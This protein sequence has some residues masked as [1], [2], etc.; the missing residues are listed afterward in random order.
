MNK[1]KPA[2]E[3][4]RKGEYFA[5]NVNVDTEKPFL[6]ILSRHNIK[7][8]IGETAYDITGRVV[9]QTSIRPLIIIGSSCFASY[10][11]LQQQALSRIRKG[12]REFG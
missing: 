11:N 1:V 7:Y 2:H 10:N 8:R 9:S 6:K 12:M 5:G 4:L 3:P